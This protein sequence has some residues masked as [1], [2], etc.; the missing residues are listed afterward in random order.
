[1]VVLGMNRLCVCV[2][3]GGG[4][5]EECWKLS[6]GQ[7]PLCPRTPPEFQRLSLSSPVAP[8]H[9]PPHH[10]LQSSDPRQ[11]S[12][13][14]CGEAQRKT[15]K[16]QSQLGGGLCGLMHELFGSVF[17]LRH[18]HT[19]TLTRMRM[20]SSGFLSSTGIPLTSFSSSPSWISPVL[21]TK[22]TVY[23]STIMYSNVL[24]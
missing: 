13:E 9:S 7:R 2:C 15:T 18:T 22:H 12:L 1:M 6:S 23:A 11:S 5:K 16:H 10:P 24:V 14:A 3:G 20:I 4:V 19:H 17:G 8:Q 21:H